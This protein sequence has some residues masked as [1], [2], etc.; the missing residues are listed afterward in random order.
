MGGT[1]RQTD[2][3]TDR[4]VYRVASQ[5]K[6]WREGA[7]LNL[8]MEKPNFVYYGINNLDSQRGRGG[9]MLRRTDTEKGVE[10]G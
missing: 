7:N 6:I 4:T 3:Q 1:R 9:Q 2:R 8:L 10:N 5:L